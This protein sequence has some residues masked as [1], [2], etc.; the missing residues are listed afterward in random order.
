VNQS[1]IW[2]IFLFCLNIDHVGRLVAPL[3]AHSVEQ[4]GQKAL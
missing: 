2:R 1:A 4:S 3:L